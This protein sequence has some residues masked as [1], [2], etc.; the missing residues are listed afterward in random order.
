MQPYAGSPPPPS[1]AFAQSPSQPPSDAAPP[2][3]PLDMAALL[4]SAAAGMAS[5]NSLPARPAFPLGIDGGGEDEAAMEMSR[6]NSGEGIG[7][8]ESAA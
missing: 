6:S 8:P 7:E 4:A 5:V 1:A 2:A 3:M